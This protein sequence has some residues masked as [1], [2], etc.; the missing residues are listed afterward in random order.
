MP[1]EYGIDLAPNTASSI[2]VQMNE[3]QRKPEPYSSKCMADWDK[4]GLTVEDDTEY[5]LSVRLVVSQYMS[6]K[7]TYFQLCLRMCYQ[8][9]IASSCS[10]YWPLLYIPSYSSSSEDIFTFGERP[11]DIQLEDNDDRECYQNK[12][13]QFEKL[14]RF[15]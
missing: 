12:I 9:A 15:V 5:S 4:T 13:K 3:I 14:N 6:C 7:M 8:E 1:D 10:C 2:A 11:C